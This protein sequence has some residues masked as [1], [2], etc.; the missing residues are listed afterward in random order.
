MI[1]PIAA[2][3]TAGDARVTEMTATEIKTLL[4]GNTI[5]GTWNG[6]KYKQYFSTDGMTVYLP[7]NDAPDEGR[8]RVNVQNNTHESWW[9]STGWTD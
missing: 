8:W 5:S 3:A 9:Q 7:A 2:S 4:A 6:S 1:L